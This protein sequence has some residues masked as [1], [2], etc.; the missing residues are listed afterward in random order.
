MKIFELQKKYGDFGLDVKNLDFEPGLVHGLIGPNGCGKTTLAKIIAGIV[1][2]D[3]CEIDYRGLTA[4]DITMTSQKPYIMHDTVLGN[5][6]YPLKL[7]G[8]KPDEERIGQWLGFCGLEE[9]R[10]AYARSLSS[11]QQQKLSLARALIF[12]PKLVIIDENLSN[13]DLDAVEAFERELTRI[14]E[15]KPITWV[16]IS[17]Q[18]SHVRRLCDRI[19][20]MSGGRVLKTGTAEDIF[21]NPSEPELKRFL[22]YS[23]GLSTTEACTQDPSL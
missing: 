19:H 20:F 4:R 8:V 5:L 15:A 1:P 18:L 16:I 7:R 13:F 12:E 3:R 23:S 21:L 2:A 10:M 14:Q 22:K 17:H 11:G 6:I 9:K